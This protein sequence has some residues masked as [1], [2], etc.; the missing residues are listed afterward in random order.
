M[1]YKK[2]CYNCQHYQ[3]AICLISDQHDSEDPN[4]FYCDLYYG[5]WEM[6][7]EE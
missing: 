3:D 1:E 7:E 5:E 4:N 6:E 2:C